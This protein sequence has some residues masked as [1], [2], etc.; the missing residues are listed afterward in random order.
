M[1]TWIL[2]AALGASVVAMGFFVVT[3]FSLQD[4]LDVQRKTEDRLRESEEWL[5]AVVDNTKTLISVKQV[6]GRY[7]TVNRRFESVMGV[8][9]LIAL[10]RRDEDLFTP[11]TAAALRTHDE[12]VVAEN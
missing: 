4:V 1:Y 12:R 9:G 6:D 10:G 3:I 2:L 11:E 8:A 7:V 5:R